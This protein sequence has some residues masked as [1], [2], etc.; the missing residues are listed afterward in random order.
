MSYLHPMDVHLERR[1]R[2]DGIVI[3]VFDEDGDQQLTL[4]GELSNSGAIAVIREINR[5]FELGVQS[6]KRQ[7]SREFLALLKDGEA[8]SNGDE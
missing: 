3:D 4:P 2:V 7:R 5:A 8:R 1:E 6:G